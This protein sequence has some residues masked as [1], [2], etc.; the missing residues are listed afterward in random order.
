MPGIKRRPQ[1][2]APGSHSFQTSALC[3]LMGRNSTRSMMRK[4]IVTLRLKAGL[5][6]IKSVPLLIKIFSVGERPPTT[7]RVAPRGAI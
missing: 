7:A 5:R 2:N 6:T 3:S 1:S 4:M